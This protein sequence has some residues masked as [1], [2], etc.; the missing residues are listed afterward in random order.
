MACGLSAATAR[1][2]SSVTPPATLTL[3]RWT[4]SWT[5]WST[6]GPAGQGPTRCVCLYEA[7]AGGALEGVCACVAVERH[8]AL[9]G[10][11]KSTSCQSRH[12]LDS[13]SHPAAVR[14]RLL[15][16]ADVLG[17]RVDPP[18]HVCCA[19]DRRR[20]PL[21]Q[22]CADPARKVPHPGACVCGLPAKSLIEQQGCEPSV[23]DS[24]TPAGTGAPLRAASCLLSRPSPLC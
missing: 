16:C 11:I 18:R 12:R 21:L 10:G 2:Q 6:T 19:R 17:A 14:V 8:L 24:A 13:E 20:T 9:G 1:G 23:P 3:T 15:T 7:H 22:D 4:T 5:T